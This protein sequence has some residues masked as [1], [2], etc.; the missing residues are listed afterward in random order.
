MA[1]TFEG[2]NIRA[3]DLFAGAGGFT[4]GAEMAGCQ[5]VWAANHWREAVDVHARNHPGTVHACQDLHQTDWTT[6]PAHDL[7]LASRPV[8]VTLG[9]EERSGRTMTLRG[10]RRG[11]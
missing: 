8:R 10:L 9:R 7:L 6:V 1:A 2:T 4:T 11:P 5:V 3:I